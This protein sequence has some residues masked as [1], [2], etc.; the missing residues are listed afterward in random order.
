M[1]R[2]CR[3][4]R[5]GVLLDLCMARNISVFRCLVHDKESTQYLVAASN[6]RSN[7]K[8][9][10]YLLVSEGTMEIVAFSTQT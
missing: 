8:Y 3:I 2:D 7:G 4:I 10:S 5:N 1:E 6:E 9:S